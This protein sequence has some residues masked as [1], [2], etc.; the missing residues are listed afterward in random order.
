MAEFEFDKIPVEQITTGYFQVA[1]KN[2]G[3][4]LDELEAG[5]KAQGLL[6]PIGVAKSKITQDND[7]FE[8]EVLW[9]QRRVQVFKRLGKKEIPAM[10]LNEV[11]TK[12]EGMTYALM[13]NI[14]RRDMSRSDIFDAIKLI[15]IQ[16][17]DEK[18]CADETGIPLPLVR[19]ALKS[20]IIDR[21]KGGRDVYTHVT[22]ICA[23]PA[24]M[25]HKILEAVR[26]PDNISVDKSKGKKLADVLATQDVQMRN[27]IIKAALNTPQGDVDGW[28]VDANNMKNY[29]TRKIELVDIED[30]A[31][32]EYAMSLGMA[33]EDVIKDLTLNKLQ[34]DGFI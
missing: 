30:E 22:E 25:A 7:D 24:Q 18:K 16:F 26:K 23:L 10:I 17:G 15:W 4:K 8:W 2:A 20:Q 29:K 28:V 11:L 31:L 13:E 21:L 6:Q 34:E 1:I 14:A 12:E 19:D 9:G 32:K 27:K 3:A 5:I 33:A